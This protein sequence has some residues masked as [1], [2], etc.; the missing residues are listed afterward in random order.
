MVDTL[1]TW[2]PVN[3]HRYSDTPCHSSQF[4]LAALSGK[5]RALSETACL[6]HSFSALCLFY[7]SS[8]LSLQKNGSG[9][10]KAQDQALICSL[11]SCHQEPWGL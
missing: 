4:S 5:N 10:V 8:F 2:L 3:A 1:T 11:S 9:A 7:H 6:G